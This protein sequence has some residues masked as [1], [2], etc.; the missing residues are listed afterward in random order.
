ML[1]NTVCLY[2][3]KSF[4]FCT[5]SVVKKKDKRKHSESSYKA[6]SECPKIPVYF[7]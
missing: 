6:M 5:I 4:P 7:V 2:A 3:K 1:S